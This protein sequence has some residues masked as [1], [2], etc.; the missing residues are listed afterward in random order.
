MTTASSRGSPR[1]FP[2]E[3]WQSTRRLADSNRYMLDHGIECDVTFSLT[4]DDGDQVNI[5]AHK[6]ILI[7]RS[8]VFFA[9]LSGLLAEKDQ[10][11]R[12]TDISPDIFRQ[13][14]GYILLSCWLYQ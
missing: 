12:I 2:A 4:R 1:S 3:D 13:I 6:F 5:D 10:K 7:S 11:I 14:L 9:M 8:P